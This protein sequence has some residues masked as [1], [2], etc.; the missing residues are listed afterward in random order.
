MHGLLNVKFLAGQFGSQQLTEEKDKSELPC[1]K[2]D[3]ETPPRVFIQ[4][5]TSRTM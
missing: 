4:F 3:K 5:S 1:S 2:L